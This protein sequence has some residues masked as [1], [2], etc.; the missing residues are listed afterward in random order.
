MPEAN[1]GGSKLESAMDEIRAMF[2]SDGYDIEWE[3]NDAEIVLTVI[4]GEAACAECLV[5]K[6]MMLK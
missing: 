4:A 1:I 2:R 6:P 5:P 3:R